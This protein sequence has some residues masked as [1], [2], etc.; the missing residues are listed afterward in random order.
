MPRQ[1]AGGQLQKQL[2]WGGRSF[3]GC[4]AVQFAETSRR[5]PIPL[6]KRGD[7]RRLLPARARPGVVRASLAG[8]QR[9]R[10]RGALGPLFL[11]AG[12]VGVGPG[13]QQEREG[14][15][16]CPWL[17]CRGGDGDNP[18]LPPPTPGHEQSQELLVSQCPGRTRRLTEVCEGGGRSASAP[19]SRRAGSGPRGDGGVVP[20]LRTGAQDWTASP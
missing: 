9:F 1:A 18:R 4:P 17:P 14:G 2:A 12:K 15:R 11:G 5:G 7:I 20:T 10:V 6:G 13:R 8:P 19:A 16:E 3:R